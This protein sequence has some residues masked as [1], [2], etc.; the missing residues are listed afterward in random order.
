MLRKLTLRDL[1]LLFLKLGTISIGGPAAHISM[2]EDEVVRRHGRRQRPD[3][4]PRQLAWLVA[5]G[6]VIGWLF[7]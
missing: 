7:W 2:M 4:L 3:Q 1:A 5:G 6:A